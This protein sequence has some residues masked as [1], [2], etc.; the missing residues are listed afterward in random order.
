MLITLRRYWPWLGLA[1]LTLI[2]WIA[3]HPG[4]SGGFL[5]DDFVNLDALGNSGPVNNWRTFWR[6]ITSGTADPTGRP[7]AL[8]SFLIDAQDWPAAPAPFLRT[9]VLL[10]LFNGALL[11]ALLRR[12]GRALDTSDTRNDAAALLGA[13]LW[14]LHP[15]FVSTT[16]YIVQ[17]EA[18]L[19][20]TF[21]LL[22]L[23]AY[24]RGRMQFAQSNGRAGN[25]WMLGGIVVGTLLALLCKGNGVL[26]PLLAWVIEATVF[27]RLSLLDDNESTHNRLQRIKALLLIV[28]SV[29]LLIY[30][31]SFLPLWNTPLS[32]RPWTVGER[33]LTESR[34][35]V[36]YLTLL[37]VPRSVSTGVYN[38]GYVV[39][40]SLWQPTSTLSA[41][42]LIAGLVAAGF[43]LRRRTPALSAA[44]LFF[45]AGHVLESTAIP[46]E[47][48]FEH[49]NYLPALLLFWPLAR[50]LCA[51]KV[52]VQMRAAIAC[53]LL[54]LLAVT[55][56]QR[57]EL[58]GHPEQL[59]ALWA[60]QN[61]DSSRAQAT[62]AIA[63]LNTGRPAEALA[64][65][66]PRWRQQPYDLQIAFNTITAACETRGLTSEDKLALAA[67][68]RHAGKGQLLI[69][70]WIGN[71]IEVAATGQ[72]TGMALSD[73]EA[74]IDAALQNPAINNA[75]IR[76]QDIE[77]L[78]AQLALRKQQ[79][80]VALQHF[81]RALAAYT[82]PDVAARQASMLASNDYYEEAL[83][84]LDNYE[85]LKSHAHRP[86]MDMS[87]LHA[88]VLQWEGY[89]PFE[90][91]LLRTKLHAA[92]AERDAKANKPR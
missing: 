90:M 21:I 32:T 9:N 43:L 62:A 52:L 67:A 71:A 73:V 58:W 8:L 86:G 19:P 44:L 48:Y 14:L 64:Q 78:L 12:L 3:Y 35:L 36:D 27:R 54:I 25:A 66:A 87:W 91:A 72:C 38:D 55:T 24:S 13:G 29:C 70:H 61:P 46:L 53:G 47:L 17:R 23:L 15:L 2:T 16:L 81:D 18:M 83:A 50:A 28:P 20:T 26:L 33:V 63:N 89:W 37:V 75:H 39:S 74:W 34:V 6:F 59:A 77:P 4:L 85:R 84:H 56:H 31:A 51:W 80:Q 45:F 30:V 7:L 10:H 92:I 60:K 5:F 49:R 1:T 11:F 42:V 79:P 88:R 65:L 41:L 69:Y 22:G 57:A 68:L 76:G 40:H 82:T